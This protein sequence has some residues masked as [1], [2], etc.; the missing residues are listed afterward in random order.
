MID[1]KHAKSVKLSN[2][3]Y[4]T[5]HFILCCFSIAEQYILLQPQFPSLHSFL[6][7]G[8]SEDKAGS[9]NTCWYIKKNILI[10]ILTKYE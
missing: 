7:D 4:I 10:D 3:L 6:H 5:V 9:S 1:C 2:N 8:K